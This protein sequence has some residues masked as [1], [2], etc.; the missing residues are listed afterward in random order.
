MRK[1]IESCLIVSGLPDLVRW[2]GG[3]LILAYHNIVPDGDLPSG[4]LSLHLSQRAFATQLDLLQETHD[5]IPLN[6]AISSDWIAGRPPRVAITF[7]DAYRG[8]VTVGVQELAA[9]SL[10]ATIF[11]A[12][13][14]VGGGTFWWDALAG[15]DSGSLDAGLRERALE[16]W[17]GV[18]RDVR[19][20]A[21]A[22]GTFEQPVPDHAR[23]ASE[24]ELTRTATVAG[25]ELGSH[26]WSHPNLARL[27]GVELADELDR[28]L[29]WLRERF[30]RVSTVLSYPYGR[31]SVAT[32]RAAAESGYAAAL[33]IDGGWL[34][35][36]RHSPYALPRMNI[37]GGVSGNGFILRTSGVFAR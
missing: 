33:R 26:S 15:A 25:I 11:V 37:P 3:T 12:P 16:L 5:V 20:G 18:D 32:Q 24:A 23:C 19:A 34:P 4:D 9:R 21:R 1:A 22:F 10:P 13:A 29:V 6:E 35:R 7:D 28:P 31:A 27:D 36:A 8:A 2:R 17:R 30:P 14:F